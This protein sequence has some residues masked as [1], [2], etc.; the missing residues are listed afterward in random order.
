MPNLNLFS[1]YCKNV[2]FTSVTI[3]QIFSKAES[4]FF[5]TID[6]TF[7]IS[8]LSSSNSPPGQSESVKQGERHVSLDNYSAIVVR[9]QEIV[10]LPEIF[11]LQL[12]SKFTCFAF[13]LSIKSLHLS[14]MFNRYL[15]FGWRWR[16]WR[17]AT[18][19]ND[20]LATI[21]CK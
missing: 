8:Y 5:V 9:R 14:F 11:L 7:V 13:I 17:N 16:Q 21:Y 3:H 12:P 4:T 10:T 6:E 19:L 1:K 2:S 20:A 15:W 18:G